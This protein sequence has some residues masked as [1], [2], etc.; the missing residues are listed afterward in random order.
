MVDTG[1][2]WRNAAFQSIKKE[3]S[4]ALEHEQ[5]FLHSMSDPTPLQRAEQ[6]GFTKAV[7][8]VNKVLGEK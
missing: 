6:E 7:V 4:A 3:L 2:I 8:V 1:V 5:R